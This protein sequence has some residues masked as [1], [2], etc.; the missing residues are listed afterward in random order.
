[1][2]D[3]DEQTYTKVSSLS[4]IL[5]CSTSLLLLPFLRHSPLPILGHSIFMYFPYKAD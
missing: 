3:W 2:L 1:V 5:Y 4:T